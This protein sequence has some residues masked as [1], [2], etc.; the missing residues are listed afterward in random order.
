MSAP[1]LTYS[2]PTLLKNPLRDRF[3]L[4]SDGQLIAILGYHLEQR[5]TGEE[6]VTFLHTVVTDGL[7]GQGYA[8]I[9]VGLA[10]NDVRQNR[11]L[12]R[13]VCTYAQGF[14]ELHPEYQDIIF[15]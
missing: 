9:L 5:A 11:Q 7:D 15:P 2:Q 3:E 4:H 8:G 10:L 1:A 13:L 14:V 12:V 6:V